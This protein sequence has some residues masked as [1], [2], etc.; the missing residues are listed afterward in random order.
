ME[1]QTKRIYEALAAPF[2]AEAIKWRISARNKEKTRGLVLAYIDA[3]DVMDRL[4]EV[5]G[6]AFWENSF[7]EVGGRIVCRLSIWLPEE[8]RWSRKEDGSGDPDASGGLDEDDQAKGGLSGAIKRAGVLHGIARY[9]YRLPQEWAELTNNGT[10]IRSVPRLPNWALPAKISGQSENR[11]VQKKEEE[12]VPAAEPEGA[13]PSEP[14]LGSADAN[15]E[16][17]AAAA[18]QKERIGI[19]QYRAILRKYKTR[20]GK[21]IEKANQVWGKSGR[22]VVLDDWAAQPDLGS[23]DGFGATTFMQLAAADRFGEGCVERCREQI[24]ALNDNP[25]P[26]DYRRCSERIDEVIKE[27]AA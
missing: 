8:K 26:D 10:Q 5:C 3:R 11:S 27:F 16:W 7:R 25:L 18:Q 15:V 13:P 22:K 20:E 1:T 4:D 17:F 21:P 14:A 19:W 23:A 6:P 12:A 24:A 9:L 2:P